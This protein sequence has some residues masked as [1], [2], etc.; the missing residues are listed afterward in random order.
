[1]CILFAFA[2]KVLTNAQLKQVT[3]R[4]YQG[5]GLVFRESGGCATT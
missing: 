5:R 1:M 2:P 3:Q 4:E